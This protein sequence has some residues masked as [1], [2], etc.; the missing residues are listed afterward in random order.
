MR[1]LLS[2]IIVVLFVVFFFIALSHSEEK[3]SVTKQVLMPKY[4]ANKKSDQKKIPVLHTEKCLD[5]AHKFFCPGIIPRET[6]KEEKRIMQ[7]PITI[8]SW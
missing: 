8:A 4:L 3:E 2:C 6:T 7:N 5:S 1:R